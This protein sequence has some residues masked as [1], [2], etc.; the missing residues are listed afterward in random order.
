MASASVSENNFSRHYVRNSNSN[1]HTR[2]SF[3]NTHNRLVP[4][5]TPTSSLANKVAQQVPAEEP[6]RRMVIS[7]MILNNFKSYFGKQE[8]GPFH[9]V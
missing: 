2:V 1:L 8:I 7:K 6:K 4:P 5:K 3:D 9:K